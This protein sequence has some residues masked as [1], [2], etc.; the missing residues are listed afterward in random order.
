MGVAGEK[1]FQ[2]AFQQN[3]TSRMPNARE[4]FQRDTQSNQLAGALG[5]CKGPVPLPP[6]QNQKKTYTAQDDPQNVEHVLPALGLEGLNQED[7]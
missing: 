6:G 3:P 1:M 7:I 5:H 2:W 4:N